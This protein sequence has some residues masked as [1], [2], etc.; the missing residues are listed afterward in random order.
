LVIVNDWPCPSIKGM[1]DD[2]APPVLLDLTVYLLDKIARIGRQAVDDRLAER[3]L[4]LRHLA[5]MAALAEAGATSQLALGQ[6]LRLDPSDVTGILD[7]LQAQGLADRTIDSAD[8]RRRLVQLTEQGE[9]T[10]QELHTLARDVADRLLAPLTP[11]RRR[12]LHNDL[13]TVLTAITRQG[14]TAPEARH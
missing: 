2:I 8:H 6:R 14:A 1:T 13:L 12:Q 4:R 7:D 5:V 10:L 9:H 11:A 3:D